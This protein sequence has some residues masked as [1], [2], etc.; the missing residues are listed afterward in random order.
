MTQS[1]IDVDVAIVGG[2]YAGMSAAL[3]IV[4]ARR[5]VAI[6]DAGKRRNATAPESHG[7]LT[8][9]GDSPAEI[10][11]IAREQVMAYPTLTWIHGEATHIDGEA[12]SFRIS[13]GTGDVLTARIVILATG[14]SDTLPD[15]PGLAGRWGDVAF[16]CP[17]CHGYELQLGDVGVIATGPMSYHHAWMLPEWGTVTFLTNN[18]IT[19]DDDQRTT[20]DQKNVTIEPTPIR[21]IIGHAD[22]LLED[23][24]TLSF[25]GLAVA[26]QWHVNSQ[27]SQQLGCEFIDSPVGLFL[28]VDEFMATTVV[29]VFACGDITT[30]AHSIAGAVGGAYMAGAAAH[31]T[32]LMME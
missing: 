18:A 28:R 7:F 10:A 5:S 16:T 21:E 31:R 11:R 32:L 3:P 22:V 14:V 23:N 6:V 17:Y 24:R 29:G 19:L 15:I 13:L 4:R 2:S 20:L 1:E 30:G 26:S 12:G 9:D 8:H 25:R 27:L